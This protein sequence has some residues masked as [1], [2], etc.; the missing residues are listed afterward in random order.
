VS[1]IVPFAGDAIA[2]RA[3]VE[4][5]AALELGSGDELIVVDNT[6]AE[7][8]PIAG[9]ARLTVL[10]A[11]EQRS[12]Y[13]ARN[14]GA[15][16]S[17]NPWLLFADADCRPAAD[18]LERYFAK[19]PHER[20]GV[21]AGEI[22]GEESQRSLAARWS[23]S[24]RGRRA[25]RELELGPRPAGTGGNMLVRRAAFEQVGGFHEG[26]RSTADVELCWRLQERGWLLEY[27]PEAIAHHLDP[28]RVR[29]LARQAARYGGGRRWTHR[30][31]PGTGERAKLVRPLAR[32]AAGAAWWALSGRFER[33]LFKLI[34]ALWAAAFWYGY[35]G[36]SNAAARGGE[37]PPPVLIALALDSPVEEGEVA[38]LARL[39]RSRGPLRLEGGA[40]PAR[41]PPELGRGVP[42]RMLEDDASL[43]RL[44]SALWLLSRHPLRCLRDLLA[45][46]R[47]AAPGLIALA[48]AVRRALTGRE[49]ELVAGGRTGPRRAE[50]ERIARLAGRRRA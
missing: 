48:P 32:G 19:R 15:E 29:E 14:V 27:R 20:A 23:R 45:G 12:S 16:R 4:A 39:H 17:A 5:F 26:I 42:A 40:R 7:T 21:V 38:E 13:Y 11:G 2:A 37:E 50:L 9:G 46:R 22:L 49:A 28:E 36:V 33:A 25:S 41:R 6:Q 44:R 8:V 43:E 31:Y 24:R 3:T 18:L 30:R 1:V 35:L 34:D 10:R 47:T